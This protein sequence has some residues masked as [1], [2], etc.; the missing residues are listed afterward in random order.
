VQRFPAVRIGDVYRWGPQALA[1]A[2][3]LRALDVESRA[4][5]RG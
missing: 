3:R 1:Q 4:L 5:G 2:R